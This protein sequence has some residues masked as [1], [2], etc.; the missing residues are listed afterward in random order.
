M[1]SKEPARVL[2][3]YVPA[4]VRRYHLQNSTAT[5]AGR[6]RIQRC[7]VTSYEKAQ[8][9]A[10]SSVTLA[11]SM[12]V[13]FHPSFISIL[14]FVL[15][16]SNPCFLVSMI[17]SNLGVHAKNLVPYHHSVSC[18]TIHEAYPPWARMSKLCLVRTR[19]CLPHRV[20]F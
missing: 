5:P 6:N 17:C 4:C 3:V 19:L 9:V 12:Q 1:A 16:W 10:D 7:P 13:G 18:I 20:P 15:S 14:I 8:I 2:P 11:A